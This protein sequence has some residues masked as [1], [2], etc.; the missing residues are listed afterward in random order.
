VRVEGRSG[1]AV[2]PFDSVRGDVR[3]DWLAE[4]RAANNAAFMQRLRQRYRVVVEGQA[5]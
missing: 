3:E 2:A 5:P 1:A 4:R